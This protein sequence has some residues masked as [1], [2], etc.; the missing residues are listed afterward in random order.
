MTIPKGINYAFTIT[1]ME[2]DSFLPE[3]LTNMNIAASTF[4]LITLKD[5]CVVTT[6]TTT[7]SI[8]D[9]INGKVK[10]LLDSTLTGSLVYERGEA[11]DGYYAKPTYQGVINIKFTDSTPERT[12]IVDKVYVVPTGVVCV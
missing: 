5:S 6:G 7:L 8:E 1:V 10:I 3:N 12:A 9:A 4:K 2:K 11:V